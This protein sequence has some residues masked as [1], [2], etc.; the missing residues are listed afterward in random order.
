MSKRLQTTILSQQKF[1]PECGNRSIQ[2]SFDKKMNRKT[3]HTRSLLEVELHPI[4]QSHAMQKILMNQ[5]SLSVKC[6]DRMTKNHTMVGMM[7]TQI[8][9]LSNRICMPSLKT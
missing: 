3:R 1:Q 8:L 9:T 5:E 7:S 6:C 2:D 4:A